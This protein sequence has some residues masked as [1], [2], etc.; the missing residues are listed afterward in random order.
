MTSKMWRILQ[1]LTWLFHFKDK[2]ANQHFRPYFQYKT[3]YI[4][5]V[6]IIQPSPISVI[7]RLSVIWKS[8]L[9]DKIKRD[10][11]QAAVVSILLYGCTTLALTKRIEVKL[12]E[13][14][15]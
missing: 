15:Q 12:E 9:S 1:G 11:F 7:G 10:F 4:I 2:E 8:D 6:I 3:L 13:I 14:A 5:I